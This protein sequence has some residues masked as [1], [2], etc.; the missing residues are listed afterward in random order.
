M[1]NKRIHI[2]E[3][4]RDAMQGLHT[5]IPTEE[6]IQYLNALLQCGFDVLDFGSFVSPKA[7]PQMADTETVLNALNIKDGGTKLLVITANRKG[8]ELAFKYDSKISLIGYPLSLS[9]T[10]QQKNTNRSIAEALVDLKFLVDT[11]P[12]HHQ[13]PVVYLS[14]GF[15]NPYGDPYSVELVV[16]FIQQLLEWDKPF[17]LLLADTTGEA[18]ANAIRLLFE[19]ATTMLPE[20]MRDQLGLHLHASPIDA[21]LKL[22]AALSSGCRNIDAALL[23]FGGCPFAKDDL[24]GNIDTLTL[25]QLIEDLNLTHNLNKEALAKALTLARPLFAAAS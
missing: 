17:R 11:A 23:G 21:Y 15:G 3:C 10:F 12:Q 16:S 5:F 9:E 7:I 18:D 1:E 4:P 2:T 8:M 20:T 25:L 22:Q 6:K 19:K 24:V 14:M 13:I